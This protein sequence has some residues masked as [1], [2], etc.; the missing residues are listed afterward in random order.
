MI[1]E[2]LNIKFV[3]QETETSAADV[4]NANRLWLLS[5][6]EEAHNQF[7]SGKLETFPEWFFTEASDSQLRFLA[8]NGLDQIVGPLTRGQ[9]SDVIGLFLPVGRRDAE[10]LESHMIPV[11]GLNQTTARAKVQALHFDRSAEKG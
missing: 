6:W 2:D 3:A 5:R 1:G 9:A 10:F 8:K 4:F 7:D 11:E